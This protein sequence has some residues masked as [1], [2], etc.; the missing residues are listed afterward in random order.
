MDYITSTVAVDPHTA[1]DPRDPH[2][3]DVVDCPQK[4]C[5][6]VDTEVW[7][8]EV[9]P[10][11][12]KKPRVKPKPMRRKKGKLSK[13]RPKKS[14]VAPLPPPCSRSISRRLVPIDPPAALVAAS[15]NKTMIG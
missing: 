5:L 14:P 6:D 9:D 11:L 3:D 15:V 7:N 10:A 4:P 2:L 13:Y 8:L 12:P 1:D